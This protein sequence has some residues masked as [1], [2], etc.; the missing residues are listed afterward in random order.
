MIVV[1]GGGQTE[2]V[3]DQMY[4][5]LNKSYVRY[6]QRQHSIRFWGSDAASV[7]CQMRAGP[8]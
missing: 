7:S 5:K 8:T 6:K 2:W 4:L 3:F 1:S